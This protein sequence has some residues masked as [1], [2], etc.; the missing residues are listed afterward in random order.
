MGSARNRAITAAGSCRAPVSSQSASSAST[1]ITPFA[2]PAAAASRTR[3]RSAA[4]SGARPR[5]A[6]GASPRNRYIRR[7]KRK[8]SAADSSVVTTAET[9]RAHGPS[10]GAA[11]SRAAVPST[12]GTNVAAKGRRIRRVA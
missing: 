2:A 10:I 3:P 9:A 8:V 7:V 4:T 11:A 1:P 5:W 12:G 6:P